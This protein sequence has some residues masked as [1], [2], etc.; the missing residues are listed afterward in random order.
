[1]S[2]ELWAR[3]P[4]YPQYE[5]SNFGRVKRVVGKNC[6]RERFLRQSPRNGYLSVDLCRGGER[7]S[8]SVHRLVAIAFIPNP[9]ALPEV[10]HKDGI[11]SNCC[12]GNLEWTDRVGNAQHSH[13]N[14]LQDCRGQKNGKAKLTELEVR[15]IRHHNPRG[16]G[17]APLIAQAFNVSESTVR[18]IWAGRTWNHL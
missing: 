16:R 11:R 18:D 15:L 6:R 10:N 8:Q 3:V 4:S 5:V 14:G 9:T 12:V 7:Q 1:M 13:D 17:F 2:V